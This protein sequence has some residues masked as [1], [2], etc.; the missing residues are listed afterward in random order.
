VGRIDLAAPFETKCVHDDAEGTLYRVTQGYE[1]V[2]VLVPLNADGHLV[3]EVL[4]LPWPPPAPSPF[5]Y[6]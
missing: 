5:R 3:R 2:W 6:L 1:V 4:Q